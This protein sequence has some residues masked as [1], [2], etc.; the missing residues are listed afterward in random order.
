MKWRGVFCKPFLHIILLS[1]ITTGFLGSMVEADVRLSGSRP[2][3]SM[4]MELDKGLRLRVMTFNMRH[5]KGQDGSI[6]LQHIAE[7]IKKSGADIIGLQEVDRYHLR[8]GLKDQIHELG[9]S[10]D[11]QW[12]FSPSLKF[13][14]TQYGNAILSK[15]P[16]ETHEVTALP[17]KVENRSVLQATLYLGHQEVH[18]LTTHLGLTPEERQGQLAVLDEV[19]NAVSE[20]SILMGDFNMEAT[21]PWID[22]LAG[23]WNKLELEP[24]SGTV[25]SGKEIDH[26]FVKGAIEASAA[27]VQLTVA[28]D[29]YPVVADLMLP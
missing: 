26:I 7:E 27:S 19:L 16:I 22:Q 23:S 28:S 3:E 5:G 29:H 6:K 2:S 1:S 11:M 21:D 10:L 4:V 25:Q 8:S 15:Y 18:I 20:P 12:V 17:G 9:K 13:G 24:H 14:F